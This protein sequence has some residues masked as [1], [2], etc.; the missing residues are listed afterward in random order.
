MPSLYGEVFGG[1]AI[2]RD[3]LGGE[4]NKAMSFH[5]SETKH[6]EDYTRV[7]DFIESGIPRRYWRR[8]PTPHIQCV[9]ESFFSLLEI[10]VIK[11]IRVN[12]GERV[13]VGPGNRTKVTTILGRIA[14]ED[15]TRDA[16]DNLP[17]VAEAIVRDN[18]PRFVSM[19]NF[20]G[21]LTPRL[22]AFELLPGIGKTT[23][24]KI[25][26]EREKMPFKSFEDFEKRIGITNLSRIITDRII[27]ELSTQQKYRL[28][29]R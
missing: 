22:H 20:F 18:E 19:L 7:L 13:Y 4:G 15:L 3:V 12:I 9:G 10:I 29:V 28:L 14:Y 11:G 1:R 25:L 6:Y 2:E 27:E 21:L 24:R 17:K 23:T 16:R 26:E 8:E 5:K